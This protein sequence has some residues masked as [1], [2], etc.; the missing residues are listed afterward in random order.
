MNFTLLSVE[1]TNYDML[2]GIT[3][4]CMCMCA[5]VMK[6][7]GDPLSCVSLLHQVQSIDG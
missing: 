5:H 6:V 7:Q 4:T 2:V 3:G 1:C